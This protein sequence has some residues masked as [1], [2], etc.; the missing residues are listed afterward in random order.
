M[1]GVFDIEQ[2][3][4]REAAVAANR[5][6]GQVDIFTAYRRRFGMTECGISKRRTKRGPSTARQQEALTLRS[7]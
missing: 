3:N 5:H 6:A 2:I 4:N 7:G 1:T